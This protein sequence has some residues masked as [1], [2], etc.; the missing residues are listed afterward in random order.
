MVSRRGSVC[1][2]VMYAD[3]TTTAY[4]AKNVSDI[5]NVKNY[6]LESL[7]NWLFSNKLSLNFAKATSV[8]SSK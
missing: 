3:D 6:E 8:L 5:S 1:A 2:L 7:R 4:S